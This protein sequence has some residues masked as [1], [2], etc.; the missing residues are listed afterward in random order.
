MQKWII[1]LV[2]IICL[3]G[4]TTAEQ[5][6]P[7][8]PPVGYPGPGQGIIPPPLSAPAFVPYLPPGEPLPTQP[9]VY[10]PY[11]PATD[12]LPTLLPAL[13]PVQAIPAAR[14]YLAARLNLT[15][16]QIHVNQVLPVE[17]SNACLGAP[18]YHESCA[19]VITPGFAI[20]LRVEQ[21]GVST[22]Y[23]L[24]TDVT[25]Q[26]LRLLP[27][28]VVKARQA[29]IEL[30]GLP[31]EQINLLYYTGVEWRNSC[32]GV[33]RAG[34]YCLDVITPG[35]LVV[36]EA[37]GDLY[38]YHTNQDGRAILPSPVITDPITW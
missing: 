28:P 29:L 33:E 26:E 20:T 24:H 19:E 22:E 17:W 18:R 34:V 12:A 13:D 21:D 37:G 4:C 9:V 6:T 15:V 7:A 16:D 38:E 35:Y 5:S 27:P 36:F 1:P 32:L 14:E 3:A 8:A 23:T 30:T 11:P 2:S 10:V 25:G 31:V